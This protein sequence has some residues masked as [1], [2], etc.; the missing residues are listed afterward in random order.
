MRK[1]IWVRKGERVFVSLDPWAPTETWK[2]SEGF[3]YDK[4][5]G[6]GNQQ[7]FFQLATQQH[8]TGR[9]LLSFWV[10]CFVVANKQWH[11]IPFIKWSCPTLKAT[12]FWGQDWSP[13]LALWSP[14]QISKLKIMLL[15]TGLNP[16]WALYSCNH[17][18]TLPVA[19]WLW[20]SMSM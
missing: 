20:H 16:C 10:R 19:A 4:C 2:I 9:H 8:K 1:V 13:L 15:T 6:Q 14:E 7:L 11:I 18:G 3:V 12:R 5:W 17:R